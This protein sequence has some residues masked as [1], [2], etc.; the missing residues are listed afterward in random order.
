MSV[1][2]DQ[3]FSRMKSDLLSDVAWCRFQ[4]DQQENAIASAIAAEANLVA[5]TQID[6]RA[7]THTRLGWLYLAVGDSESAQRHKNLASQAWGTYVQ[8]QEKIVLLLDGV[9]ESG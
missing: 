5:D 6:D 8:L 4:L 1:D 3:G 7:A 2:V 9:S